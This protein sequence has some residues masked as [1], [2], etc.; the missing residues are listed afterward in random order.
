VPRTPKVA[1][2]VVSIAGTPPRLTPPSTLPEKARQVFI[3]TVGSVSASHFHPSDMTLLVR[4]AEVV[5]L[6]EQAAAALRD[7]GVVVAGEVSAW[8]KVY[9]QSVRLQ[10]ALSTKLKLSPAARSRHGPVK[11]ERPLS[12]PERML[13]EARSDENELIERQRGGRSRRRA[14]RT[15]EIGSGLKRSVARAVRSSSSP[16]SAPRLVKRA[17]CTFP[18]GVQHPSGPAILLTTV[19]AGDQ[20]R[21][22]YVGA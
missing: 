1:F 14:Q 8:T 11:P 22:R 15:H 16:S 9:E 19:L 18:R 17:R 6:C 5:A 20:K 10:I 3:D 12:V 2:S 7:G 21:L 4:Y 13:L